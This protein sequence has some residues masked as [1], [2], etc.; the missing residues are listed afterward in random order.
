MIAD[1]S[2]QSITSSAAGRPF[3]CADCSAED[4]QWASLNRGVLICSECCY[5]H[6]NLGRHIS[7]VRS[8]KKGAWNSSQLELM[9]VLYS[10]GSNNIWE[11]S[12]LD[13]QSINKIRRKPTPHDPVLPI[14]EN[15]I[16]AKYAQMAFALRPAKDDN[17]ISQDDLNRQ[18]WSCVRTSHVETTMRLLAMGA[19]PNYIDPEKHNAPLHISAKENQA[20]Q[21]ELLWIYGADPAQLN[22]IDLTPSQ[23]ARLE[24][25]TELA[26]RLEEL[27]FEV[28]NRLTM[29]LCGRRPDHSRQQYFLIPELT[30]QNTENMQMKSA[31]RRLRSLSSYYFERIVQDVYDEV[32]R[33]ETV[34]AWN[35]TTQGIQPFSLGNDHCVAVFLPSNPELSATRN[36]LRQKL[37]KCDMRRFATLIIDVLNEAKRRYYGLLPRSDTDDSSDNLLKKTSDSVD[38]LNVSSMG[39]AEYVASFSEEGCRDYDEVADSLR[40]RKW[41]T[42]ESTRK[43][44]ERKSDD[45]GDLLQETGPVMIDDFLELKEKVANAESTLT[46]VQ[47]ANTQILRMLTHLQSSVDRLNADNADVHDELKKVQTICSQALI[48]RRSSPAPALS[49]GTSISTSVLASQNPDIHG[50]FGHTSRRHG[51][52]LTSA[53][54]TT[55]R[56]I[57]QQH[58]FPLGQGTT[59]QTDYSNRVEGLDPCVE[60]SRREK[61]ELLNSVDGRTDEERI[62]GS[63]RSAGAFTDSLIAETEQLTHAIKL[64]LTDAQYG[65]LQTHAPDHAYSVGILINRILTVVPEERR[66]PAVEACLQKMSDSTVILS[67]KCNAPMFS[68]NDTCAAAFAVANSAKQ[69]L[70]NVHQL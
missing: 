11:H 25:H 31:R 67:A 38:R 9:Y 49:P 28:T 30:G 59:Q 63:Y 34:V 41:R 61:T 15:F 3:Q 33:R 29:F 55:D 58:S 6:R 12:L 21:V 40:N 7:H 47:Q 36:Q 16:K 23:V 57:A 44:S 8:I 19:D 26:I 64:L 70:V 4:P 39:T 56:T 62:R 48:R 65:Q 22:A 53:V 24:N 54:S 1:I 45:S 52:G 20:L 50:I 68:V 60:I 17:C 69:L 32:D 27:Q 37:A 35:A 66:T 43:S 51:P 2:S 46:A 42:S 18:L 13:P 5:V 14:K 10:N